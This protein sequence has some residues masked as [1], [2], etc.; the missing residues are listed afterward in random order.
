MPPK[1]HYARSGDVNIAYQVLG[2]GPRDLVMA[3]GF[4]SNIEVIWKNRCLRGF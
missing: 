2:K 1:T 4:V 3:F